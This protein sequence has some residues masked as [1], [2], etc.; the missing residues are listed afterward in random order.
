MQV[1]CAV[2]LEI[3]PLY[4]VDM[5]DSRTFPKDPHICLILDDK[6]EYREGPR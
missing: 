5:I 3:I 1:K 6:G 2:F 4:P